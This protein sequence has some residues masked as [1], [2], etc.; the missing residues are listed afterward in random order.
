MIYTAREIVMA[1]VEA[2]YG[3]TVADQFATTFDDYEPFS[4][5]SPESLRSIASTVYD[6]LHSGVLCK[7]AEQVLQAYYKEVNT[8]L[9]ATMKLD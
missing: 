2:Q 7:E 6:L 5:Q 8:Y 9:S 4:K 3:W 1:C